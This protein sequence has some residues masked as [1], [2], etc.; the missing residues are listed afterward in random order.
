MTKNETVRTIVSFFVLTLFFCGAM[1]SAAFA[2]SLPFTTEPIS[3]ADK[4]VLTSRLRVNLVESEPPRRPIYCFAV[5]D[6]GVIAVA[7]RDSENQTVSVYDQDGKFLYSFHF[8]CGLLSFS[9]A[10]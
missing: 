6:D 7:T 2:L 5:R 3:G 10:V 9:Q 8:H 4:T 1:S